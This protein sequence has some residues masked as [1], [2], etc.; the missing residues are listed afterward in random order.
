[1]SAAVVLLVAGRVAAA[2]PA[3]PGP[4]PL[5][6]PSTA[7]PTAAYRLLPEVPPETPSEPG[8]AVGQFAAGA[9]AALGGAALVVLSSAGSNGTLTLPV[10]LG[11]PALVGLAVCEVGELSAHYDG[12]CGP[13]VGGAVVGAVTVIPLALLGMSL[14]H[15]QNDDGYYGFGGAFAG[16]LVGWVV[17]QPL[18]ATVTWRLFKRPRRRPSLSALPAAP[19]LAAV[20]ARGSDRA[21][22]QVTVSLLAT[23]F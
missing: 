18:A 4:S 19:R 9:G 1:V 8:L 6:S 16:A 15:H 14:D 23:R 21:A 11:T 22:G 5:L 17:V 20:P 3:P 2:Q 7:P 13:A 12:S 10:L